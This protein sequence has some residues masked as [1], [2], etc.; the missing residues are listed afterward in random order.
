MDKLNAL[1]FLFGLMD[2]GL[3]GHHSRVTLY[4]REIAEATCPG[5]LKKAVF[6]ASIH[7]MGKI[8]IPDEI[9][10]KPA[11]LTRS[12]I[13]L[14]R[15]HSLIGAQILKRSINGEENREVVAAVMHHH[16]RWDGRGYPS[17]LKEKEIPFIARVLAVADAFDAM[18]SFRPYRTSLS[19]QEALEELQKQSGSQFDPEIADAFLQIMQDRDKT[20]S[21][22]APY[23]FTKEGSVAEKMDEIFER[24]KGYAADGNMKEIFALLEESRE[25]AVREAALVQA[26]QLGSREVVERFMSILSSPEAHLRNLAV[27]A[28]QELGAG[29]I[30]RLENL[31]YDPDPDLRILCFNILAGVRSETAAGP[32][33]R[34]LERLVASGKLEQ[35][36]VMAAALECLGGLGGPEDAGL[37]EKVAVTVD[38][39]GDYPY[40]YLRYALE[41]VMKNLCAV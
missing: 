9:L 7:D 23:K 17:S 27:E 22:D 29:Y 26:I 1:G 34:F 13:E 3:R 24:I 4:S 38:R 25:P 31:L 16:E 19:M 37:L 33:R 30:D 28:L 32:V 21:G 10:L 41:Q 36:N 2:L 35:Q 40:P 39:W 11:P 8:C 6:A 5:L 20:I 12:E 15:L 18:T 14:V